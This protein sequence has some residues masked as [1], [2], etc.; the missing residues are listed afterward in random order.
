MYDLVNMTREEVR[1]KFE[2]LEYLYL[3]TRR[4]GLFKIADNLVDTDSQ[5]LCRGVMSELGLSGKTHH[6]QMVETNMLSLLCVE[7]LS[8]GELEAKIL[9]KLPDPVRISS[10]AVTH[11]L[12]SSRENHLK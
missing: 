2:L 12:L 4:V 6:H 3:D 7:K 9:E 5:S 10:E 11:P 8:P 1:K